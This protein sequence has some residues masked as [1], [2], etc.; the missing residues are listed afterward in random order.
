MNICRQPG[1]YPISFALFQ[2]DLGACEQNGR[3]S[4]SSTMSNSRF[5]KKMKML[6]GFS[7]HRQPQQASVVFTPSCK[8]YATLILADGICLLLCWLLVVC[9][10]VAFRDK[11][12][13]TSETPLRFCG[14]PVAR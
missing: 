4:F 7:F 12:L 6:K 11:P 3:L 8:T 5:D 14:L 13:R 10:S 2:C 1:R 9:L